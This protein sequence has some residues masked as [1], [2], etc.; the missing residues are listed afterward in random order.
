MIKRIQAEN[1]SILAP[2]LP[3][4]DEEYESLAREYTAKR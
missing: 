4:L 1:A 2:H 3:E